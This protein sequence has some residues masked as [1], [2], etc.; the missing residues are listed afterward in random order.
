MPLPSPVSAAEPNGAADV[1]P[2]RATRAHAK[3]KSPWPEAAGETLWR[4][5][6]AILFRMRRTGLYR[7]SFGGPVVDR[8]LFHPDDPRPVRLDRKSTRLNSSH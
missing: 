5:I 8:I 7:L 6:A 1:A 2:F 3:P 4:G